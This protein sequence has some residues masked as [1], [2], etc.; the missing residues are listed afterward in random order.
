MPKAAVEKRLAWLHGPRALEDGTVS[1]V[2]KLAEAPLSPNSYL[3]PGHLS[4]LTE[5]L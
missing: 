1:Q 4:H 2:R 3:I 5:L